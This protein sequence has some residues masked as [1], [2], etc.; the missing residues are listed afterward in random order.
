VASALDPLKLLEEIRAMQAH[1][2]ALADGGEV[3][4]AT[5]EPPDLSGFV[6]SLSSTWRAGEVRPTFS[7]EAKPRYLR[8]L[9]AVV[10][11][12]VQRTLKKDMPPATATSFLRPAAKAPKPVSERPK[13]IYATPGKPVYHAFTM[14]WPIVCRRLEG[15]PNISSAQLFDELCIRFPG[16]FHPRHL[17]RQLEKRVKEWR[18]DA[19]ARGVVIP[20]RKNRRFSNK[21]RGRAMVPYSCVAHLTEMHQW[22]EEHPDQTAKE[23][24]IEFQARY[25]GTYRHSHLRT[26]RKRVQV[27][28]R[29]AIQRLIFQLQEHTQD[30]GSET[31]LLAPSASDRALFKIDKILTNT[32]SLTATGNI[33][34]EA[35]GNKI[36]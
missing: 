27:W 17:S 22:L 4:I 31:E 1:L 2:V 30:V 18:Q 28:R 3:P 14:I 16:R 13:P 9:Q 25:P 34:H 35:L 15:C 10:Q 19:R 26:L 8:T 5:P 29:E 33:V 36:T 20:P 23:V 21:P 11:P 32:P 6:A 24:L 12:D 7:V